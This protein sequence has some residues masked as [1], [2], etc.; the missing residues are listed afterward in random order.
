MISVAFKTPL[1]NSFGICTYKTS[2]LHRPG[3]YWFHNKIVLMHAMMQTHCLANLH[4]WGKF[5]RN[6]KQQFSIGKPPKV[7]HTIYHSRSTLSFL[8]KLSRT[9]AKTTFYVPKVPRLIL[10]TL[11]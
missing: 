9:F 4:T 8:K 1:K 7:L 5:S 10:Y 2:L 11:L 3:G 6:L